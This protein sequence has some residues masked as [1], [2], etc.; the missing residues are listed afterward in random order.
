MKKR[1]LIIK[2]ISCLYFASPIAVFLQLMW[3]YN[4]RFSEIGLVAEAINWHVVLMLL[5][6][7]LVGYGIWV[8]KKWGYYLLMAHTVFLISNNIILFFQKTT[9]L[10]GFVVLT[11]NLLLS[12]LIILFVR[13]EV[14]APYFNPNLRWWEQATRYYYDNMKILIKAFDSEKLVF[15]AG[16]FDVSET[17]VFIS[18][19]SPVKIGDVFNLEI[20][21]N[22]ESI[23]YTKGLVVWV[24][25][26]ID[27]FP[28]GFGCKF[29]DVDA[30]FKKRIRFHLKDINAKIRER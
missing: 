17:G 27:K 14:Y 23:L 21:L 19:D 4:I 24:N 20:N 29:V 10:P 28:C 11:F 16:S 6:T 26:G 13:K 2:I 7:P 1:P 12:A 8:V 9:G 30:V 5:L 3:L 18:T 15:E 25:Q 22:D